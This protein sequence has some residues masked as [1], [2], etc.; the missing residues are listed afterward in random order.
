V[1]EDFSSLHF[2]TPKTPK[3]KRILTPSPASADVTKGCDLLLSL[4][5]FR[6]LAFRQFGIPMMKGLEP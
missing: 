6:I 2:S 1:V 3:E 4:T 5:V